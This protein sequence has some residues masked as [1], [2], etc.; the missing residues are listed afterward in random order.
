[1]GQ[2]YGVLFNL[3][4]TVRLPGVSDVAHEHGAKIV[5][6]LTHEMGERLRD[7]CGGPVLHW[8][9]R[10]QPEPDGRFASRVGFALPPEQL[11]FTLDWAR[12]KF[13]PRRQNRVPYLEFSFAF[14]QS[15]NTALR[16]R[17]HWRTVRALI[18]NLDPAL[19]ERGQNGERRPLVELLSI[20]VAWRAPVGPLFRGRVRGASQTLGPD[21]QREASASNMHFL[22]AVKDRAWGHLD[23]GWELGEFVDRRAELARRRDDEQRLRALY[24]DHDELAQARRQRALAELTETRSSDARMRLRSWRGWWQPPSKTPPK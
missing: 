7:W 14:C 17:F 12:T 4:G 8:I 20:P 22:S 11:G 3:R 10:H 24:P 9:Y 5:A 13:F 19:Q 1:M 21:A 15:E 16:A 2:H 18:R 6:D 23:S